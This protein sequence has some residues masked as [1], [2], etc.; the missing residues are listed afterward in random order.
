MKEHNKQQ[1]EM[2]VTHIK[3]T[4]SQEAAVNILSFD[5]E[6]LSVE[7]EII[8]NLFKISAAQQLK[9]ASL[10]LDFIAHNRGGLV[11]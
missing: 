10:S 2:H 8:W 9:A 4:Q 5:T 7:T 6:I 3:T 1:M 11:D